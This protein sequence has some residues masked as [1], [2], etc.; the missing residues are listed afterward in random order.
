MTIKDELK[1]KFRQDKVKQKKE[2]RELEGEAR[3]FIEEFIIPKFRKIAEKRPASKHLSISFWSNIGCWY[4]TSSEKLDIL[5]SLSIATPNNI[6]LY[7]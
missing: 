4:Y 7:D 2:K 5:N 1:A 6:F 3:E